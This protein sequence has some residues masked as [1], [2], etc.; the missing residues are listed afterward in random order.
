MIGELILATAQAPD[1][2]ETGA[3]WKPLLSVLPVLIGAAIGY[4][5]GLL[6]DANKAKAERKAGHHDEVLNASVELLTLAQEA[7]DGAQIWPGHKRQMRQLWES[8]KTDPHAKKAFDESEGWLKW[9]AERIS[10]SMTVAQPHRLKIQI[11]APSLYEDAHRLLTVATETEPT[12]EDA[13]RKEYQ[14]AVDTFTA[15]VR[16]FLRVKA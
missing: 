3:P 13:H 4:L 15:Q 9:G 2:T 12:D 16:R 5:F 8:A 6:R 7:N 1:P 14:E 11:L 10:E